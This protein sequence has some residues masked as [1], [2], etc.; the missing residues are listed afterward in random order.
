MRPAVDVT[1][2]ARGG[3]L[4]AVVALPVARSVIR[5]VAKR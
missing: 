1:R 3:Q 4:V 5:R 2:I